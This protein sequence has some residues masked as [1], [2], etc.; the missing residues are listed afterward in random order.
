MQKSKIYYLINK[1]DKQ[2]MCQITDVVKG[3]TITVSTMELKQEISK[4][5]VELINYT[6]T[7]DNRL[8]QSNQKKFATFKSYLQKPSTLNG[9]IK[10]APSDLYTI[11]DNGLDEAIKE[12]LSRLKIDYEGYFD[13]I[14]HDKDNN[15]IAMSFNYGKSTIITMRYDTIIYGV[16]LDEKSIYCDIVLQLLGISS[17]GHT[18]KLNL[19][20]ISV[21]SS[22]FLIKHTEYGEKSRDLWSIDKGD[23]LEIQYELNTYEWL[24]TPYYIEFYSECGN[25]LRD[26]EIASILMKSVSL[27]VLNL[28]NSYDYTNVNIKEL[29]NSKVEMKN[30]IFGLVT[31]VAIPVGVGLV[32]AGAIA[33][34]ISSG[35]KIEINILK[36]I[37][38]KQLY[39]LTGPEKI[40][41]ILGLVGTFTGLATIGT[42]VLNNHNIKAD[43]NDIKDAKAN[44][45]AY[46]TF[47]NV[48]NIMNMFS[49]RNNKEK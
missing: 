45:K 9:K 10:P 6:L 21:A 39:L 12:G 15:V 36:S 8:V 40:K 44:K 14:R 23:Y 43:I 3:E 33:M 29:A 38:D 17:N 16:S 35:V 18:E 46:K 47:S 20:P 34:L 2:N 42:V 7:S 4:G 19:Q 32:L 26:S 11:M 5:N 37:M 24:N 31:G 27:A 41:A 22:D 49:R 30:G 48:Q 13:C 28:S 1:D 25:K